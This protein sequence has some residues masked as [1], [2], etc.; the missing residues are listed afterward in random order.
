[1]TQTSKLFTI[2]GFKQTDIFMDHHV[3]V[4]YKLSNPTF[5]VGSE[6]GFVHQHKIRDMSIYNSE[7]ATNVMKLAS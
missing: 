6:V 3:H 5:E 4:I 1:M 7:H 2:V